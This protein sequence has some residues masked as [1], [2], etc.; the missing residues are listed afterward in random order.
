MPAPILDVSTVSTIDS[1]ERRYNRRDEDRL[2]PPRRRSAAPGASR[3]PGAQTRRAARAPRSRTRNVGA[4]AI[5]TIRT[6]VGREIA[7]AK[8]APAEGVVR[9]AEEWTYILRSRTRWADDADTRKEF[10]DRALDDLERAGV[11]RAFMNRLATLLTMTAALAT[12]R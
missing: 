11:P 5:V 9:L 6:M 2:M 3:H 4:S 8:V 12:F 1:V 7:E 10:R